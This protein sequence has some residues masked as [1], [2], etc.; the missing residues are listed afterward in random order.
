MSLFLLSLLTGMMVIFRST[1]PPTIHITNKSVFK[2]TVDIWKS[3]M[4]TANKDVNMKAI[5]AVMKTAW[6][7]VKIGPEKNSGLYGIWTWPVQYR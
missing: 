1:L 2:L 6:A 3:Y 5:F 4:L 7:V